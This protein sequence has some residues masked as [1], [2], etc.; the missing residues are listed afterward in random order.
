MLRRR[1]A[2]WR[3]TSWRAGAASA[4]LDMGCGSGILAIATAKCWPARV[5]AVDN[6]PT[7]VVVAQENARHNGVAGRVRV[8]GGEGYRS[9]Q[10]RTFGPTI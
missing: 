7:A 9:P 5:V 10:V 3:S 6:D 1:A 2:C 8:R 4:V